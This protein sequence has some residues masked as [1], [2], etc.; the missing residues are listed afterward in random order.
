MR[1]ALKLVR[2]LEFGVVAME[3]AHELIGMDSII[4]KGARSERCGQ[5]VELL[6]EKTSETVVHFRANRFCRVKIMTLSVLRQNQ[7]LGNGMSVVG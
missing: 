4:G 3:I 7:I 1:I 2:R 6:L 5:I